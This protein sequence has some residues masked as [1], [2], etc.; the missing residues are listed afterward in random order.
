MTDTADEVDWHFH[1]RHSKPIAAPPEL[2]WQAMHEVGLSDLS[3][4]QAL[5]SLRGVPARLM[6]RR[7]KASEGLTMYE[8][9]KTR[10]AIVTNDEPRLFEIGRIAKF[11]QPVPQ[12]GPVAKDYDDFA[13][14]SEPGYAKALM[15]FEFRPDGAATRMITTTRVAA[16][17]E[18]SRRKF[19]AY[20]LLIRFGAGAIR[21]SMLAAAER[22]AL[23]LAAT[24]T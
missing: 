6:G 15:S 21:R 1:M 20:W 10:F 22:R 9:I 3:V 17:D 14:F 16:T 4:V 5:I 19:G 12:D 8:G 7:F 18:N 23:E 11:W 13:A 24:R 2:V